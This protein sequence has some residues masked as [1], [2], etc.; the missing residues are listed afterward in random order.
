MRRVSGLVW[1]GLAGDVA[2]NGD[3]EIVTLILVIEPR[4]EEHGNELQQLRILRSDDVRGEA[5]CE[6]DESC[7]R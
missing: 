6:V 1:L 2:V 3:I 7:F 5:V 4:I